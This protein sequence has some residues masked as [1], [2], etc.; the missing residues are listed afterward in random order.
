VALGFALRPCVQWLVFQLKIPASVI[1]VET[2]AMIVP[3]SIYEVSAKPSANYSLPTPT[4]KAYKSCTYKLLPHTK[5][6]FI[7]SGEWRRTHEF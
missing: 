1:T 3:L 5:A 6:T 2:N 7:P 4:S